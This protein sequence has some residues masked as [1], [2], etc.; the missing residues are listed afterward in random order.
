MKRL[1]L[2]LTTAAIAILTTGTAAWGW[3]TQQ[4]AQAFCD[5]E[6]GTIV[7]SATF[8]NT[9]RRDMNVEVWGL[10]HLVPVGHELYWVR[11]PAG[12]T[13]PA[14]VVEFHL[15]W[16]DGSSYREDTVT[17][18]MPAVPECKQMEQPWVSP[19]PTPTPSPSLTQSATPTP[20]PT[21]TTTT[22]PAPSTTPEPSTTPAPTP[23]ASVP[24]DPEL[25]PTGLSP[26]ALFAG[27]A[28]LGAGI[29][30]YL[31]AREW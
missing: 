7:Q 25:P 24:H 26:F 27:L 18:L 31:S 13:S 30:L 10:T 23:S 22:T 21:P 8:T 3:S 14:E 20:S 4:Q 15:T 19:S 29:V 28:L 17:A 6:S 1:T 12:T 11:E 9:D 16:A 2:A 5:T